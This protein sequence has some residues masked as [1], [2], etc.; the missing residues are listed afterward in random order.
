[1]PRA[2]QVSS[3]VFFYQLG[4]S[5]NEHGPVLQDWARKLGFGKPTGIDLPGEYGGLVPDRKWRD[6][7]LRRVPEVREEGQVP[8]G[9]QEALFACGGIE[10]P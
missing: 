9:T 6:S 5:L 3:D 8:V 10:R 4:A 2:L 7:G 1:M